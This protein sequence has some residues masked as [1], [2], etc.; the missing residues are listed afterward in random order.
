MVTEDVIYLTQEGLE[1]INDELAY[2]LGPK[3]E[4]I[5]LK[6]ER[7]IAQ[8]DL[9]ENADYHAAKEDQGFTEGRI[10][11][12]QDKLRR[13]KVI[14][15]TLPS[16]TVQIGSRVTVLEEGEED[17]ETYTIVGQHEADPSNGRISNESPFGRGLLGA[18]R[19]QTVTVETPG[20]RIKLKIQKIL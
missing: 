8:G 19:G 17:S 10:R 9:K 20:G 14:K 18:K 4:E 1:K 5:A 6:L 3:R 11:D 7:A 15:D 2:L 12:L 13:A 16:D